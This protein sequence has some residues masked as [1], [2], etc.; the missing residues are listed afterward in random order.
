MTSIASE[1]PQS[2]S[3]NMGIIP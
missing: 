1:F 3:E 2:L